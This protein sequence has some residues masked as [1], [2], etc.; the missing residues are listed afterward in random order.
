[1]SIRIIIFDLD[2]TLIDS[3]V[4]ITNALNYALEPYSSRRLTVDDS[5][6]LVG[7]GITRLM[8]KLIGSLRGDNVSPQASAELRAHVTARFLKHY[9]EHILDSTREYPGVKETLERLGN[10]QKAVI[11]NKNESLSRMVLDGLG[12][13]KYFVIVVGSDTTPERKPSP[14]PILK[15]LSDLH[16]RPTDAVIVGDSNYDIDAGKAAAITTVA[17]T[18]GYRPREVIAHADYLIDRMTDLVPLLEKM[19]HRN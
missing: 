8:E 12:L 17:V 13:S 16:A 4:D 18:Y 10:Y 15:V 14:L 11:S 5:T 6:K 1:M 7:E 19:D 3:S 9:T 2:G